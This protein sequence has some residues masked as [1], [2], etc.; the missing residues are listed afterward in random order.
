MCSRY[1]LNASAREVAGRFG[2]TMPPIMPNCAEIRPTDTALILTPDGP[3][4][5][6]WGLDVPWDKRPLINARAE[7]LS[8]KFKRLLPNRILIPA[9]LWFEWQGPAKRK[10]R[11]FRAD[12]DLFA[13]AG[14]LDGDRF[15]LVTQAPLPAIAQIHDR[16]PA[17][18]APGAEAQW[19]GGGELIGC[20]DA[21][22][23]VEDGPG[24]GL[25]DF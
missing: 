19:L 12:K 15:T 16:M 8:T 24:Q 11:L 9:S 2:L 5:A 6:R 17:V 14:L 21:F 22:Q 1:E 20:T 25:F 13:F 7:T 23:A 10:H 4:L 18:L 3:Q